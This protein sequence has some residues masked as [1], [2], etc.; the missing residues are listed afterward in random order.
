MRKVGTER[1]D[2]ARYLRAL[3]LFALGLLIAV[4]PLVVYFMYFMWVFAIIVWV[5]AFAVA[6]RHDKMW[7]CS[8]CL[9]IESMK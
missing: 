3:G 1:N 4:A 7:R 5:F 6:V 8:E 2:A 9:A